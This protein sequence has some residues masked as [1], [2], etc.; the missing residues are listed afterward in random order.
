MK[1][2][3]DIFNNMERFITDVPL[4]A[5]TCLI[6]RLIKQTLTSPRKHF[7]L[8][9]SDHVK[10]VK[11]CLQRRTYRQLTTYF[12]I[13]QLHFFNFVESWLLEMLKLSQ[14]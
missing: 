4:T 10:V 2:I 6:F 9:L 7:C 14:L 5:N 1:H 13:L 12:G 3:L 11:T 8:V